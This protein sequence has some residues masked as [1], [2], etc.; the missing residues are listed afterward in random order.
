VTVYSP[1]PMV[2]LSVAPEFLL[3]MLPGVPPETIAAILAARR[4]W[5][6]GRGPPPPGMMLGGGLGGGPA[7]PPIQGAPAQSGLTPMTNIPKVSSGAPLPEGAVP[8]PMAFVPSPQSGP[9]ISAP[10]PQSSTPPAGAGSPPTPSGER[11]LLPQAPGAVYAIRATA[12]TDE[13]AVFLREAVVWVRV[14]AEPAW[15]VLDWREGFAA[16]AA[17]PTAGAVTRRP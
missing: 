2:D 6:E 15:W 5:L 17:M 14:G 13:G 8:S 11:S 1:Q 12:R 4:D 7:P 10:P 3:R 16:G 9:Q